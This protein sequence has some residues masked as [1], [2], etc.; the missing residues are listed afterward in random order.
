[1]SSAPC[2]ADRGAL[3]SKNPPIVNQSPLFGR[4]P[5]GVS[6][7]RYFFYF[8]MAPQ[9]N[10]PS[11]PGSH[12]LPAYWQSCDPQSFEE[13][14][15]GNLP[16]NPRH[17]HSSL[18]SCSHTAPRCCASELVTNEPTGESCLGEYQETSCLPSEPPKPNLNTDF[19][20]PLFIVKILIYAYRLTFGPILGGQC[21][22]YPT[23]SQYALDAVALYGFKTGMG[24]TIKRVARCHPFHPGGF[25]PA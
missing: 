1:M 9:S 13:D 22:F 24:K 3:F 21:R 20:W 18:G 7:G 16:S 12:C 5:Q 10:E 11:S 25:D 19:S 2:H 8:S 23:C 17:T 15:T 6:T 14:V 4:T